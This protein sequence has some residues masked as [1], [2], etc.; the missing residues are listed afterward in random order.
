M[1]KKTLKVIGSRFWPFTPKKT[2]PSNKKK[3]RVE[4]DVI[5]FPDLGKKAVVEDHEMAAY[6]NN[7]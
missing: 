2:T 4:V 5:R 1:I 3:P 6:H 7:A